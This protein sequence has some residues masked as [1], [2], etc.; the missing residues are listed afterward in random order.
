VI[1]VFLA[2]ES[3]HIKYYRLLSI[4][5]YGILSIY[6]YRKNKIATWIM[7]FLISISGL[8]GLL[9]GIFL[10]GT[11]QL[12]LKILFIILGIY[13]ISCGLSLLR[14]TASEDSRHKTETSLDAE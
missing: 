5:I 12:F 6:V 11:A 8:G 14:K 4:V 2:K 13:F 3:N 9:I 10:I 7:T 1:T